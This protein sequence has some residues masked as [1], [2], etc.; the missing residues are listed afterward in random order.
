MREHR[1]LQLL[2]ADGGVG[3]IALE[4]VELMY[5]GLGNTYLA[6]AQVQSFRL[7]VYLM[8]TERLLELVLLWSVHLVRGVFRGG[9]RRHSPLGVLF[10]I[11]KRGT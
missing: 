6:I 10:N 8:E 2:T 7:V 1:S 11:I 9:Q 3:S 5:A 4:S